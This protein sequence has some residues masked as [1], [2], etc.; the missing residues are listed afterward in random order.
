MP[1]KNFDL[2]WCAESQKVGLPM[3]YISLSFSANTEN[4][5]S[6]QNTDNNYSLNFDSG[7]VCRL[8]SP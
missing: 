3:L 2:V 7:F 6:G 1:P 5:K 4:E 8:N